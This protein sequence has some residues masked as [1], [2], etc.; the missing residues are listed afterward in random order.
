VTSCKAGYGPLED[1]SEFVSARLAEDN[2]TVVFSAHQ[3]TYRAA[4]GWR[5]FPDGGIPD[6]VTDANSLGVYDL[7]TRQVKIIRH[8]RNTEWQPGSGLYTIH[9]LQGSKALI[10]Q[11]GQ[12]RGPF[13]LGVRYLLL[14]FKTG[15]TATLDLKS[16]LA[17]RKRDTGYIYLVDTDGTLIFV[18]LSLEE[19]K[20][21]RAY[22]N[23][24]LVPEIW[25]RTPGGDYVR[26][27]ASTHYRCVRNGEVIYWE[28][29]TRAF[30]AFDITNRVTRKATEYKEAGYKNVDA[31]VTLSSDR[32]SLEFGVKAE[33]QWQSRQLELSLDTLKQVLGREIGN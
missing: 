30:M 18:T 7:Q 11:G 8:E 6:Y 4:T 1:H 5:A 14:D 27:A 25:V 21:A 26:A 32:K 31:G 13:R 28:P 19:A 20:D 29:T 3:F 33:G 2:R 22:R 23:S 17:L 10:T 9:S 24:A 16:D 15:K 12:L